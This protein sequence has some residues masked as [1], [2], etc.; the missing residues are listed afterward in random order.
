MGNR[1]RVRW[2]IGA[3]GVDGEGLLLRGPWL[4]VAGRWSLARVVV[5]LAAVL[6]VLVAALAGGPVGGRRSMPA[7]RAVQGVAP[8]LAL[9]VVAQ[10]VIGASDRGFWVLHS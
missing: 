9:Q 8:P 2:V 4:G 1:G 6:A 5:A 7:V 3:A 10:Q